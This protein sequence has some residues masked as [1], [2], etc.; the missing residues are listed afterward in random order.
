[1][2]IG[3]KLFKDTEKQDRLTNTEKDVPV[4][5]WY[6]GASS[7]L[8]AVWWICTTW[9]GSGITENFIPTGIPWKGF[10]D[11]ILTFEEFVAQFL[12]WDEVF[13]FGS[14]FLWMAY[15]FWDLRAAGML[16]EGWLKVVTLMLVGVPV[17]G[18][19][20]T[21][22]LAWLFREHILASRT[23]KGA[24]TQEKVKRLHGKSA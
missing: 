17:I 13:G 9:A 18:P 14:H 20:A 15:L 5:K 8:G 4:M 2:W 22:G 6:I 24:L 16:Q 12:R 19:G 3:S 21:L 1:M 10:N 11:G 7:L 23:H